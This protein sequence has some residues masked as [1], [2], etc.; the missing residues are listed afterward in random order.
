MP[1][2]S[3]ENSLLR[4]RWKVYNL[5]TS[6]WPPG[7]TSF[8]PWPT[9]YT[10]LP[11]LALSHVLGIFSTRALCLR[12]FALAISLS[13]C[14]SPQCPCNSLPHFPWV[15][16]QMTVEKPPLNTV[17]LILLYFSLLT[18]FFKRNLELVSF[19]IYLLS[20]SCHYNVSAQRVGTLFCSLSYPVP[21]RLW[22]TWL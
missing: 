18:L 16:D 5:K 2:F 13:E 20:L 3:S 19:F 10:A 17:P 9:S 8:V 7:G 22:Y 11:L 14:Y 6:K 1:F 4:V 15:F 12:I 21:T